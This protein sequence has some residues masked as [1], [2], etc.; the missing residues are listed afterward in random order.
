VDHSAT[1][2]FKDYVYACWHN[3]IRP[4]PPAHRPGRRLLAHP[5]QVSGTE[6]TG[7]AIGCDVKTNS[8]GDAIRLLPTTGNSR[9]VVANS[10]QRRLELAHPDRHRHHFDSL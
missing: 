1:S 4:S 10:G 7:T 5:V 9:I 2:A 8:A 6:S 3:A